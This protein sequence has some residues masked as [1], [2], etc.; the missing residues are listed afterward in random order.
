MPPHDD[1]CRR[2]SVSLLRR[3]CQAGEDEAAW[4]EF[5]DLYGRQ[6]YKWCQAWQLQDAD[7][8]DLTQTVLLQLVAKMKTFAYDPGRSFRAWL[9][10][11]THH[12]WRD[13]VDAQQRLPRGSGD[14]SV[15]GQLHT[16][17]A[18]ED[19]VQRLEAQ[20][21][22]ELLQ[23]AVARVRQRV[24]PST[25]DAFRL[26]ALEGLSGAAAAAQ[27]GMKAATVYV[28]RSTVQRMLQEEREQLEA[29][30]AG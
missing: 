20:F 13:W 9:K 27:L 6:I 29:A 18:R 15:L 14:S 1:G 23:T 17:A 19:L 21:D 26:T 24:A 25:W 11:V 12:A 8:E 30:E 2:T 22:Q 28:A 16:I 7:A 4:R 3:V 5:I 10:T